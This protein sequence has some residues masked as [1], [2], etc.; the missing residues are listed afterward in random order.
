MSLTMHLLWRVTHEQRGKDTWRHPWVRLWTLHNDS[1]LSS[2]EWTRDSLPENV[3]VEF[4]IASLISTLE[5][6]HRLAENQSSV[7]N[8][9][10]L[11]LFRRRIDVLIVDG[12]TTNQ[13]RRSTRNPIVC[14]QHPWT[15]MAWAL[16]HVSHHP[17]VDDQWS[18]SSCSRHHT[19][20]CL[21]VCRSYFLCLFVQLHSCCSPW[22]Q[23]SWSMPNGT[24]G[25]ESNTFSTHL[26]AAAGFSTRSALSK[27]HFSTRSE[28]SLHPSYWAA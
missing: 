2:R 4:F 26:N 23:R 28:D 1:H 16:S 25:S 13:T 9:Y 19:C 11:L 7:F 8:C 22:T 17:L 12:P 6:S 18:F 3:S 21:S 27:R 5:H 15:S 14:R 24:K 10:S 20:S